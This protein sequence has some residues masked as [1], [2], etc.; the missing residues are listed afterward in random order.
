M[1]VWVGW[2][3]AVAKDRAVVVWVDGE[4][5]SW[6][7]GV[8]DRGQWVLMDRAVSHRVEVC[9]VALDELLE[10]QVASPTSE[11]LVVQRDE[12]WPVDSWVRLTGQD[13]AI[14]ARVWPSGLGRGG[15]GG[16]FGYGAFGVDGEGSPGL[17]VGQLG[18][19]PLGLDGEG[20]TVPGDV[21]R[22]LGTG[23]S[24]DVLEG[25][26]VLA[27]ALVEDVPASD[28]PTLGEIVWTDSGIKVREREA[29]CG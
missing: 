4:L 27:K 16:R 15:F 19:G 25:G 13:G 28:G 2:P 20:F 3:D 6:T 21:R 24:L 14:E 10:G 11:R 22:A 26:Q 1:A 7:A 9:E 5:A 23:L 18:D 17:G 29:V 12:R 8:G